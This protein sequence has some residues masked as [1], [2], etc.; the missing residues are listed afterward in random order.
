MALIETFIAS[1]TQIFT[2][3]IMDKIFELAKDK[4]KIALEVK[5]FAF[6]QWNDDDG[7]SALTALVEVTNTSDTPYTISEFDLLIGTHK[8]KNVHIAEVRQPVI[9]GTIVDI[10]AGNKQRV[11][12]ELDIDFF[13][14]LG[15]PYLN[16]NESKLGLIVFK[17]RNEEQIKGSR[18]AIGAKIAG[19]D[20][21]AL[22]DI[23]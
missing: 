7:S 14:P 17:L 3:K 8:F 20:I 1:L 23:I 22:A 2:E 11:S 21:L 10:I 18:L 5:Y 15:R 12:F 16:I 6:G 4:I 13:E 9:N 19:H